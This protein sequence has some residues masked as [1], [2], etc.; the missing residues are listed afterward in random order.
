MERRRNINV[1][2]QIA[3]LHSIT[4]VADASGCGAVKLS[5]LAVLRLVT[6]S[7]LVGACTGTELLEPLEECRETGLQLRIVDAP[8]HQHADATHALLRAR[9]T[10]TLLRRRDQQ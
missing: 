10:A 6:V 5:A 4:S 9:P 1:H 3:P 8:G 2:D 7:Y